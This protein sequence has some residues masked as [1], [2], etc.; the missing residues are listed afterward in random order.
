[1][2][3]AVGLGL[4]Q[5]VALVPGVS[6]SGAVITIGMLMGI[7]REEAARFA[8]LLGVPAILGAGGRAVWTLGGDGLVQ[9]SGVLMVGFIASGVVGYLAVAGLI[10]YLARHTLDLFAYYRLGVALVLCLW[11][12]G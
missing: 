3:E 7:R 10:R 12:M 5:A 9:H 1:M 4:A 6:R 11:L 2:V 8:F